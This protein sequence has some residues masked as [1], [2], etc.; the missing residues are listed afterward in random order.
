MNAWHGKQITAARALAGLTII[1]LANAAGVTERTIRRIEAAETITVSERMTHGAISLTTWEKVV[2]G[3]L[4]HGVEL[5][6]AAGSHGGG[7]RWVR[8]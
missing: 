8:P 5:L 7:V 4:D 6:H 2:G 1:E 3:L